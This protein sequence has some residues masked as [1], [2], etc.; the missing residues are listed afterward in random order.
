MMDEWMEWVA[1]AGLITLVIGMF[2]AYFFYP[3]EAIP[4]W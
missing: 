4:W 1:Y 3:H 2:V